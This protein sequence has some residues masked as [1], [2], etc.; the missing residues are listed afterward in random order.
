M[1]NKDRNIDT[2][3]IIIY[4]HLNKTTLTSHHLRDGH[5]QLSDP[6]MFEVWQFE[7]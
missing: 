4:K 6:I 1:I 7:K 2:A 3:A 5:C